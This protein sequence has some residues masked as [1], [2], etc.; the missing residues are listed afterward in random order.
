MWVYSSKENYAVAKIF[1]KGGGYP[2]VT[3]PTHEIPK[4]RLDKQGR[5]EDIKVNVVKMQQ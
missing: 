4:K 5:E 1:G 2:K 3:Y